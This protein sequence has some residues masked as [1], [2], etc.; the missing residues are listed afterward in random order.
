MPTVFHVL[1]VGPRMDPAGVPPSLDGLRAAGGKV[2][3]LVVLGTAGGD[4]GYPVATDLIDGLLYACLD[5]GQAEVPPVVVVPGLGDISPVA[6]GGM[7]VNAV[8]RNWAEYAPA[9]L[10]GEDQDIVNL[11][12]TGP[13]AAFEG[14][15]ARFRTDLTGWHD[16]LLPGEGSLRLE[17]DGRSLGLVAGN[18][19]FRMITAESSAELV[20]LSREQLSHAVDGRYEDWAGSNALNLLLAGRAAG[21]PA[22]LD[23]A[24]VGTLP[25]AADPASGT[26]T[27]LPDLRN[28]SHRLLR[29]ECDGDAPTR[30]LDCAAAGAP[31]LITLPSLARPVAPVPRPRP[32]AEEYDEAAAIKAFYEQMSTGRAV[33]VIASGLHGPGGPVEVDG[34]HQNLVEE[35]YGETPGMT[36]PLAE[37]WSVAR[38]RL[39]PGVLDGH[40]RMLRGEGGVVLPGLSRLLQAPWWQVYDFTASGVL[41]EACRG[42]AELAETVEPVDARTDYVPGQANRLRV[43]AMHG[44]A[45][46]GSASVDFGVP[47]E[48]GGDPR[49]LWFQRLK[50][51]LLERPAVFMAASPSSPALWAVLDHA[52]LEE[53]ADRYPLFVVAPPGSAGEQA[54]MRLKGVVHIQQSPEEFVAQRLQSDLQSLKE[55]RRRVFELR[56]ATRRG[57]GISLVSSLLDSARKGSSDFLKGS[58]PT[59]GDIRG[60]FTAKLSVLDRI[61]AGARKNGRGKY[62]V[63]LVEGRAGTG[64][65]TALMHH[66]YRL[67]R[68][69]RTVGWIDRD[70]DIP[71]PEIKKQASRMEFDTIVID[72]VDIF[73]SRAASLLGSLSDD[74]RIQVIAAIRTT[75][76]RELDATFSPKVVSADEPL[77]DDDLGSVVKVLR[78]HGLLGLLKE[79]KWPP[80]ARMEK[81]RDLCERSLLAAMIHV[82]SGKSF[83]DKVRSDFD[84]LPLE[85]RAIY[86]VMCVLEADQVYKRRGME[87]EDLLSVMRPAVSMARTRRGIEELA[88]SKYLVRGEVGA[89][90]CRH[91]T[92]ADQVVG[93]VLKGMPDSLAMAVRLPL[94]FYAG[95]ARHIRDLDDP[96]RRIMIRLLNHTMMRKLGLGPVHVRA[97]YDSV[98]DE[99]GDDFH[100]WL[101]RGEY[102][103]ERGDLGVAQN[104]LESARGCPGGADDF[105]VSTAW[106]AI[107]LSR[108]AQRPEDNELRTKALEAVDVLEL[109]TVK[110]GGATPHTFAVLSKR[111]T[112]WLEA[113]QPLLTTHELSELARRITDVTEKGRDACRDNHTFLDV[114]DRYA[115][116]LARLLERARGVPL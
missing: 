68:E 73:G 74:G 103:L 53:N 18:S 94:K 8:T 64:K 3:A 19:V 24:A 107:R 13:F 31:E 6:P 91:R 36:P 66:A 17:R 71:L 76:V 43:V 21:L 45:R 49:S 55:G 7:L 22:D 29:I 5:A 80:R 44:T 116:R 67:H 96:Y 42:D 47:T 69:G 109:V 105:K 86:S 99:L 9:L 72:D 95:Q 111:G 50:S 23:L 40:V 48:A 15:A 41:E 59:W 14:W 88:R 4:P 63:V 16:G 77:S 89:L 54:R 113:V 101:Q 98:L 12:R 79:Y 30:V 52:A 26:W 75:R 39:D 11:L 32:R 92:I 102:E 97:I 20:T 85:E 2:D 106:G 112:E 28:R 56:S 37:V 57:T 27:A 115:T 65:T 62:P 60:D 61:Q 51:E 104:H 114:A 81:L 38:D 82:V 93:S 84:D 100:Y 70:T 90:Y 110:H 25:V 1:C 33:L 10:A 34:F 83:E 58:D 87:Q 35:L 78:K 46:D 108:S